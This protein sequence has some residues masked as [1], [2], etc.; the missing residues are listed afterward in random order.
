MKN[1]GGDRKRRV[2]KGIV[3]YALGLDDHS[4]VLISYLH[5]ITKNR[6][7]ERKK[8]N[9]KFLHITNTP[10]H[11]IIRIRSLKFTINTKCTC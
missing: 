1:K 6:K 3:L 7:K 9:L 2:E 10:V 8:K 4:H 5:I 11:N